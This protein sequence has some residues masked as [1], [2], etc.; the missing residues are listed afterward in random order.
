[1]FLAL[2]PADD[3]PSPVPM[4]NSKGYGLRALLRD[5]VVVMLI[6]IAQVSFRPRKQAATQVSFKVQRK[7]YARKVRVPLKGKRRPF[8]HDQCKVARQPAVHL[9]QLREIDIHAKRILT[10]RS[11]PAQMSFGD[12]T[13]SAAAL[14]FSLRVW[15][16]G[17]AA[18]RPGRPALTFLKPHLRV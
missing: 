9:P 2:H 13:V 8:Y 1:M 5:P 10:N 3:A 18:T 14:Q 17:A 12:G 11:G 7:P 15:L 4:G 6:H 16:S